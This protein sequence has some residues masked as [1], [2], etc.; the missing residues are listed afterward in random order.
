LPPEAHDPHTGASPAA[1]GEDPAPVA[2]PKPQPGFVV[3]L[4]SIAAGLIGFGVPVVGMLASLV[5]IGLGIWS[6]RQG[7]AARYT[8]SIA[9][10]LLGIALSVLSIAFW[11][12]AV[13]FESYH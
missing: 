5:G 6:F 7:R 12:C 11:V 9:C 10:G 1:N 13:L 3:S 8:P 4:C 2:V